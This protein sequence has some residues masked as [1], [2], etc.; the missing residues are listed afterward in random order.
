MDR[1]VVKVDGTMRWGLSSVLGPATDAEGC[2]RGF[3]TPGWGPQRGRADHSV[4]HRARGWGRWRW[5]WFKWETNNLECASADS[6]GSLE[7]WKRAK[8]TS[9]PRA[10][11]FRRSSRSWWLAGAC[12][13][14]SR[15][16]S[17]LASGFGPLLPFTGYIVQAAWTYK[18]TCNR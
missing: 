14:G 1:Q 12:L 15:R 10:D 11:P 13:V 9:R 2:S 6:G 17:R 16:H 5:E 3:C 18:Y 4:A 7:Q 8:Y